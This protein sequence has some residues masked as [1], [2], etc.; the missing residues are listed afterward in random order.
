[1]G[2]AGG[3]ARSCRVQAGCGGSVVANTGGMEHTKTRGVAIAFDD[4]PWGSERCGRRVDSPAGRPGVQS[5]RE[6]HGSDGNAQPSTPLGG[7]KGVAGVRIQ[8]PA[9]CYEDGRGWL[10]MDEGG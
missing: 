6:F 9:G 7:A 2:M 8:Q 3:G 10:R 5:W 4:P 1:M